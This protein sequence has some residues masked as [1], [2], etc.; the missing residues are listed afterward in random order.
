MFPG[1]GGSLD[2]AEEM[3]RDLTERE[4][5]LRRLGELGNSFEDSEEAFYQF[6]PK[7]FQI[8]KLDPSI[9][10]DNLLKRTGT[11]YSFVSKALNTNNS[12]EPELRPGATG[13]Q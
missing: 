1:L 12:S 8:E 4:G 13:S 3:A 5:L 7:A 11:L 6:R 10:A 9:P 2:K